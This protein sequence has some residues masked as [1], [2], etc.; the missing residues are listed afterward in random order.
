MAAAAELFVRIAA[1]ASQYLSAIR[2]LPMPLQ[3]VQAAGAAAAGGLNQAGRAAETAAEG[4]RQAATAAGSVGGAARDAA[5]G[6]SHLASTFAANL[7]ADLASH[8]IMA[9]GSAMVDAGKRA[10]V[11]AGELEQSKVA[12]TTMLGSA[13]KADAFLRDLTAFAAQTPFELRGLQDSSKKLLAFGFDARDI[14]PIM[15]SVGNAVAGLG[16]GKDVLDGVTLALGQMAAKG[17][18]SAEEMGQ[19]AERG[20][21]AWQF[22]ADKIGKS[23][24]EAMKMAEKGAISGA[25]AIEAVI[26]GMN[27]KFPGMMARQA[28]TLLGSWSNLVDGI[29]GLLTRL[30]GRFVSTFNLTG[31]IQGATAALGAMIAFIDAGGLDASLDAIA[32]AALGVGTS[33]AVVAVP[34]AVAA[35]RTS[36]IPAVQALAVA[37]GPALVAAAP[38]VA[39]AGAVAAAALPIIR[40]WDEVKSASEAVWGLI[41]AS[42]TEAWQYLRTAGV[43]GVQALVDAWDALVAPVK[44]VWRAL[45]EV[46]DAAWEAIVKA[47]DHAWKAISQ[48]VKGWYT[49]FV[50]I[51]GQIVGAAGA[52]WSAMADVAS[53]WYNGLRALAAPVLGVFAAMWSGAE[54]LALGWLKTVIGMG[55]KVIDV[56]RAVAANISSILSPVFRGIG[57]MLSKAFD[58]LPAGAQ[59]NLA[60][61]ADSF[62]NFVGVAGA[63]VQPLP[64]MLAGHVRAAGAT[65]QALPA[66]AS[67]AFAGLQG[68][69]STAGRNFGTTW[70][71]VAKDFSTATSA[72]WGTSAASASAGAAAQGLHLAKA[73][74]AAE[75]TGKAHKAAGNS[76]K[77]AM[78]AAAREAKAYAEGLDRA[79]KAMAL[80][81]SRVG[82]LAALGGA[83]EEVR[84]KGAALGGRFDMNAEAAARYKVAID[85]LTHMGLSVNSSV[86]KELTAAMGRYHAASEAGT[87]ATKEAYGTLDTAAKRIDAARLKAELLGDAFDEGR[88]STDAYRDAIGTM[89]DAGIGKANPALIEAQARLTG[90]TAAAA[91]A[92][93]SLGS[94]KD[95][96][97][98]LFGSLGGLSGNLKTLAEGLG[99]PLLGPMGEAIGKFGE[100]G[101]AFLGVQGAVT[102]LWPALVTFGGWFT[103][104]AIPALT[105][106][107]ATIWAAVVPAIT[108]MSVALTANP[109]G[110]VV[111]A[112]AGL[113]LA[114]LALKENWG[115]VTQFLGSC[116]TAIAN[117][118]TAAF[119][120]VAAAVGA[121]W[122][123]I[124]GII[125]GAIN[126]IIGAMNLLVRGLNSI[127]IT[128]P[129][130]V[131]NIGGRGW[132]GMQIPEI[133]YLAAGGL[134]T[135]PAM[136]MI[137]EGRHQ[138]AVLPLSRS[139]YQQ[140]A[141]GIASQGGG[142][143][144]G[145]AGGSSSSTTVVIHVNYTGSGKWTRQDARD[146]GPLLV[147]E[148]RAAGVRS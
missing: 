28:Q 9:A 125:K 134:T 145:A 44:F 37:W 148:L 135:G 57:G 23:V 81:S 58:L 102:S 67:G 55:Q 110:L 143:S 84:S 66:A 97:N 127:K 139:T 82:T 106:F 63:I 68:I 120:G 121:V 52:V 50:G 98:N 91:I 114:G 124:T 128:I 112:I 119:G 49:W 56:F 54:S 22:L 86:V 19:L 142:R 18:A 8:A 107:G 95:A 46:A 15:T 130:W 123:G 71:G 10:I 80:F 65:F 64:G 78:E 79:E 105:A 87:K 117:G 73:A 129:D 83:M 100:L 11:L 101:S 62:K 116:W 96:A 43:D 75:K 131:P 76:S 42:A 141:A 25:T 85:N 59:G 6:L 12:F 51:G 99:V 31:I 7:A 92:T 111:A 113:I 3:G 89:V 146:L 21:P 138:E 147:S 35:I 115:A 5:G 108:A 88:V 69:A 93:P 90:V 72:M 20:I 17:K 38:Y 29:D 27:R 94:L 137:G 45:A 26:E 136:A 4:M 32:A 53:R 34:A 36:L 40:Q 47:A 74:A 1:D 109:I 13:A 14:I 122:D 48:T 24:P 41:V 60:A 16:G 77:K 144:G 39:L 132:G 126:V 70:G 2:N 33:V 104:A 140:I 133:P 103:T 30:G 118:A 61:A